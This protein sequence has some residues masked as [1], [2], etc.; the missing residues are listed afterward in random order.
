MEW[1]I[2]TTLKATYFLRILKIAPFSSLLRSSGE[3]PAIFKLRK[4]HGF[5]SCS[6][7]SFPLK[8]T[9]VLYSFQLENN[10]A[11]EYPPDI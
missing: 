8:N 2:R 9:I 4:K 10:S 6:D 7:I 11:F 5:E 1:N 3:K